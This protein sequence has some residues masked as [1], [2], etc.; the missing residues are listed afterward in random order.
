MKQVFEWLPEGL[1]YSLHA[2]SRR[3]G[4]RQIG[5]DVAIAM[6]DFGNYFFL[7]GNP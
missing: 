4:W 6:D 7:K 2:F 1:R 5:P 3:N